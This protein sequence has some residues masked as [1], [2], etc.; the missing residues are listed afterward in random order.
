MTLENDA[1]AQALFKQAETIFNERDV[2]MMPLYAVHD[3][4]G[5]GILD[6]AAVLG[7]DAVLLGPPRRGAIHRTLSGD[8]VEEVARNLPESIPLLIH[9]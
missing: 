3:S 8:I 4:P 2:K 5:E 6:Y 7:A 9:A 1:D